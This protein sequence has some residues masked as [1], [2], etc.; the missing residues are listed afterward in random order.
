MQTKDILKQNKDSWNKSAEHFF[1][2]EPLPK[3]FP[4]DNGEYINLFGEIKQKTFLELACGS[5]HSLKYI[6]DNGAEKAY[7]LDFSDKQIQFAKDVNQ[8]YIDNGKL[9]LLHQSME[10]GFNLK[11]VDIAYSI[12]GFGWTQQ[13]EQ[14]LKN[15]YDSLKTGGLFI[16]SWDH[17]LCTITS[18]EDGELK[19]NDSYLENKLLKLKMFGTDVYQQVLS[20]SEWFNVINK[21]GFKIEKFIEISP[22]NIPE[23]YNDH[24]GYYTKEKIKTIPASMIWVLKK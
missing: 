5:G 24:S 1:G 7:G 13:P 18:W 14:V 4:L 15:I 22:T 20:V 11:E 12:Y 8:Q 2:L 19:F 21:S 16:W 6:L 10:E 23:E 3:M 9:E 17:P